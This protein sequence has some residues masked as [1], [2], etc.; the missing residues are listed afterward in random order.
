MTKTND[1]D[2]NYA[3]D[4]NAPMGKKRRRE[5]NL[6]IFS[7]DV[8]HGIK[9]QLTELGKTSDLATCISYL[10]CHFDLQTHIPTVRW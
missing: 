8:E 6:Q 4:D 5:A 2:C 9:W 10:L 1:Y 7:H 3:V